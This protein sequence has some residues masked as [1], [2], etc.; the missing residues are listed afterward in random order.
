MDIENKLIVVTGGASGLGKQIAISLLQKNANVAVLD[1]D[2]EGLEVLSAEYSE[3]NCRH[4]D[5]TDA[6]EVR[7]IVDE[8]HAEFGT[9][10][11]LINNAGLIHSEPLVNIMAEGDKKHSLD[12]WER[13]IRI[14]LTST[15]LVGVHVAEKMVLD[16]TKGVIVNISSISASGNVGQSAYSAAKAGVNALTATWAKELGVMGIRVVA[17]SPGF[18]ATESTRR[19]LSEAALKELERETPLR[20][21]GQA[22][23]VAEAVIFALQNDHVTGKVID[24]DGGLVM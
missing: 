22:E 13:I 12:T 8:L 24:V 7:Q 6:N 19:A 11:A 20:R 5:V 2:D 15:F 4:C 10:H 9:I 16:R 1:I 23:H 18:I 17:V 14:N 21:L 3:I